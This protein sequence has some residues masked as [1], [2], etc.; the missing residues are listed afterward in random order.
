M[1]DSDA[2]FIYL[3]SLIPIV[4]QI[5]DQLVSA[6]L[7]ID[8]IEWDTTKPATFLDHLAYVLNH[9]SAAV[10]FLEQAASSPWIDTSLRDELLGRATAKTLRL[11]FV[12]SSPNVEWP[13][14]SNGHFIEYQGNQDRLVQAI[15]AAILGYS[16][17]QVIYRPVITDEPAE[18][19][20]E[21]PSNSL[22][23]IFLPT[24]NFE[25]RPELDDLRDFWGDKTRHGVLALVGMGGS[26]KTALLIRFLQELPDNPLTDFAATREGDLPPPQGIFVW[27]FY[28]QPNIEYFIRVLYTFLTGDSTTDIARDVVYR[29]IHHMEAKP[30][31]ALLIALDGLEIVQESSDLRDDFGLLRDSSLRHLVRRIAQ[32]DLPIKMIITSRYPLPELQPFV[33]NGYWE[34]NTNELDHGSAR[35][36]LHH[37]GI[38]GTDDELDRLLDAYG[39]H[40]LTLQLLG[41]VLYEFFNGR[42]AAGELLPDGPD[43]VAEKQ[44][45][46]LVRVLAYIQT[47]LPQEEL[48]ILQVLSVL[49]GPV[50]YEVLAQY[51]GANQNES[52][53]VID[54]RTLRIC[55]TRLHERGLISFYGTQGEIVCTLHPAIRDYFYRGLSDEKTVHAERHTQLL[56]LL[57]RSTKMER[58]TVSS[59]LD[60]YED[61]I[62]HAAHSHDPSQALYLYERLGGYQNLAWRLGDYQRGRRITETLVQALGVDFAN[63]RTSPIHENSLYLLDLGQPY[64]AEQRT[65]AL[66]A[67]CEQLAATY[68]PDD[69]HSDWWGN[70]FAAGRRMGGGRFGM[71]EGILWQTLA[72]TL[73]VQGWLEEARDLMNEAL[74]PDHNWQIGGNPIERHSGSNPYA[75]RGLAHFWLGNIP[76]ALEDFN[77]ADTFAKNYTPSVARD[78]RLWPDIPLDQWHH[79]SFHAV[80][81]ARLGYLQ[82]A[83]KRLRDIEVSYL[84]QYRPFLAALY[85]LAIAEIAL[86]K[87]QA[88]EVGHLIEKALGWAMQSG[89]QYVYAKA[90]LIQARLLLDKAQLEQTH[91]L[92]EEILATCRTAHFRLLEVDGLVL[93][94][95]L[96]LQTECYEQAELMANEALEISTR[97]GYRWG[98]GDA[99]YGLAKSV[100]LQ[101]QI[102]RALEY[103]RQSLDLRFAIRDPRV[104]H[105]QILIQKIGQQ[106]KH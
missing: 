54:H 18:G 14:I 35:Q 105:T 11:I 84:W 6:H 87:G 99:T 101:G 81:L 30:P 33:S 51:F 36:L 86:L 44:A 83:Q 88:A 5:T 77:A 7:K 39:R 65:R 100:Y 104:S 73:L 2:C 70:P 103:A 58:P 80:A 64:L 106:T 75:R 4:E 8:R 92:L 15:E 22:S 94:V 10:I 47:K 1:Y 52:T 12:V 3:P 79:L 43:F 28:D 68:D 17:A 9:T 26:G 95:H 32:G 62:Y 57:E 67:H 89:H 37:R 25:P 76:E 48:T 41:Q 27:S 16:P 34:I 31:N 45:A 24:S 78:L 82:A 71:Y 50:S 55:L 66:I 38:T 98:M 19:S 56:T 60:I 74:A 72:D 90:L 102:N 23:G 49:R 20:F 53:R 69:P 63:V 97:C 59:V 29:L 61:M 13:L 40:P 91:A 85:E 21:P 46:Q 93:A 96:A 42:A